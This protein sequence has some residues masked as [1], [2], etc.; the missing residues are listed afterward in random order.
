MDPDLRLESDWREQPQVCEF[1]ADIIVFDSQ[2]QKHLVRTA[3]SRKFLTVCAQLNE[4]AIA[5]TILGG[6]VQEGVHGLHVCV[7]PEV[8][9][10]SHGVPTCDCMTDAIELCSG[11][12][13]LG[14]GLEHSGF[15]IKVRNDL[16]EPYM[17]LLKRQ[18]FDASVVGDIG[19]DAT[20]AKIHAMHPGSGLHAAGFP[21]Q[22]WS[23]LGDKQMTADS[24]GLT[25]HAILRASYF[26]R[27]HS[28]LLECVVPAKEDPCV[29]RL[30]YKWCKTT[31]YNA[32]ETTLHLHK[33]WPSRR[34]RWWVL[35]SFPGSTPPTLDP[36]PEILPN[37]VVADVIV[38]FPTWSK[39][40]MQELALDSYE[41]R[42]FIEL[43]GWH[44][45]VVDMM[46]PLRT[47]LHSLGN[48]FTGCPCGCRTWPLKLER[49]ETK[50][51]HGILIP[52]G[53]QTKIGSEMHPSARYIH[54]WELSLL[55]GVRPNKNWAPLKLALSGLG[56]IAS[57]LQSSWIMSQ[58][59]WAN[60]DHSMETMHTP[61]HLLWTQIET[62]FRERNTKFPAHQYGTK[63]QAFQ[64]LVRNQLA[65]ASQTRRISNGLYSAE[66]VANSIAATA[67][68][69]MDDG[70]PHKTASELEMLAHE[71]KPTPI[72]KI[73]IPHEEEFVTAD[74]YEL[75]K[76][77]EEMDPSAAWQAFQRISPDVGAMEPVP[78]IK[79]EPEISPNLTAQSRHLWETSGAVPGFQRQVETAPSCTATWEQPS[80]APQVMPTEKVSSTLD[81]LSADAT[82]VEEPKMTA[83]SR[84]A[85]VD[86]SNTAVHDMLRVHLLS[87][88]SPAFTLIKVPQ[89]T[90]IMN[91]LQAENALYGSPRYHSIA[92]VVG[93]RFHESMLVQDNMWLLLR[94]RSH[95]DIGTPTRLQQLATQGAWVATDEMCFYMS[96]HPF[97]DHLRFHGVLGFEPDVCNSIVVERLSHMLGTML[98][99]LHENQVQFLAVVHDNHWIPFA[100]VAL[101]GVETIATTASGEQ[102][103]QIMS[104]DDRLGLPH[105]VQIVQHDLHKVFDGDCGFQLK[106]WMLNV[107]SSLVDSKTLPT[108]NIY[109][110]VNVTQAEQWRLQFHSHL[111]TSDRG[112][113]FHPHLIC[114]GMIQS[115]AM[116]EKL[117]QLLQQHG[118]PASEL[119]QRASGVL[120]TLGRQAVSSCF[121]STNPWK[122]LKSRANAQTP[123]L[124]LVMQSEL[125]AK[126]SE[127][128]TKGPIV[129]SKKKA[130]M[131]QQQPTEIALAPDD[132]M[133]PCGIF[134]SNT[135]MISQLNINQIGQDA[136]GIVTCR[137]H[138]AVPYLQMGRP[139]SAKGLAL[140]IL[141]HTHDALTNVGTM[142]RFPARCTKTNEPML[143][144]AKLVQI[145]KQVVERNQ[146]NQK[147]SVEQTQ[148]MVLRVT[149][150]RDELT[151]WNTFTNKPVKYILNELGLVAADKNKD[152][153]V[154]D[155]WDR[156]WLT[157]K[158]VKTQQTTA[159]MYVVNLRIQGVSMQQILNHS[160]TDGLYLEPRDETGRQ[161]HPDY[162]VVWLP[163]AN[164]ASTQAAI[165][166]CPHWSAL[167]RFGT[168]Y[169]LQTCTGH[170]ESIH[171]LHKP[172]VPY[173]HSAQ[174]R[175]FTVGPLPFNCTR[176]SLTKLFDAWSWKA[177]PVQP[178]GRA[179]DGTGVLWTIQA[180]G[181][182]PS[183]VYQME[184]GDIIITEDDGT[185]ASGAKPSVDVMASQDG[186]NKAIR[187]AAPELTS[188]Q[189]TAL[190][191]RITEKI[192]STKEANDVHM[193]SVDEARFASLEE[194]IA[195]IA[196]P[197]D[198]DRMNALEQRMQRMEHTVQQH[199]NLQQQQHQ[200]LSQSVALVQQNID[201]QNQNIHQLL[202]NRFSEQLQ[203]I[204]RLI[205]KKRELE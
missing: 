202:D 106:I 58:Y 75:D 64:V 121:R 29:L 113:E 16:R 171:N 195:T 14:E 155:V 191:E 138:E 89:G 119:T 157:M 6:K 194:R 71:E 34:S 136:Q 21:C 139:V 146:P 47:A 163:N 88:D 203:N 150:F 201:T 82:A 101:N 44:E 166:T 90:T 3:I 137:F 170:A 190:E 10:L 142:Q 164:R 32:R 57:P 15:T 128:A 66:D 76:S 87:A 38:E 2:Q 67:E 28:V 1:L 48:H 165:Q 12:G 173:L 84:D 135:E 30:I 182:P 24:R 86:T 20:I 85:P 69:Y 83:E 151:D 41:L 108:T 130:P 8:F 126:I 94:S 9:A 199:A 80:P 22:P 178:K 55:L 99:A 97:G 54:P 177:R 95:S 62:L 17:Q 104:R 115:D 181:G 147:M 134:Q 192:A 158:L 46:Q 118:V 49:L 33:L 105:D 52:T 175:N 70:S 93:V 68:A 205:A 31:G 72:P 129:K 61:E 78:A 180:E 92:N 140:L 124:Q 133:I 168:R 174:L 197:H 39:Q 185:R 179:I 107:V 74:P 7:P 103:L 43:G 167:A 187:M 198:A 186:R 120:S 176:S 122:E 127:K 156:Q 23:N 116:Q 131:K 141:D 117:E 125:Q 45:N 56:Q 60:H 77:D 100:F 193:Q 145:G 18:G 5:C 37:P 19:H 112:S 27:A 200:E 109:A 40:E 188:Q 169:G 161:V 132:I 42:N 143:V 111:V 196:Q 81:T 204:E 102:L 184:H 51:I 73:D 110:W 53:G 4:G 25:L 144:T 149:A 11:L 35:L 159:S 65:G 153:P 50:G 91:I 98:E 63:T 114:G 162:R 13:A 154:V 36:F 26:L 59:V 189:M 152:P 160:G 96:S 183:E 172:Q 79:Q 123:L 148:T